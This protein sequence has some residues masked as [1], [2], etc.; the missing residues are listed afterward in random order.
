M[1]QIIA[2]RGAR[3]LAPE[4]TL[5]SARL[6]FELGAHMWETD[7]QQ[8]S[9]GHL[10]LLHDQ[11]LKRCT[12]VNKVFPGRTEDPVH[13]FSLDDLLRLDA[14]SYYMHADPFG[15]VAGG[16]V[17][18]K[19]SAKYRGEPIPTL[20]KALLFTKEKQWK[21]N[22]ELKQYQE[23]DIGTVLPERL[24]H[25]VKRSGIGKDNVVISSFYHPWLDWINDQDP[26]LAVQALLGEDNDAELEFL[27]QGLPLHRPARKQMPSAT[28][29]RRIYLNP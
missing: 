27:Q 21:I 14:G 29:Y 10:I 11:T 16:R 13:E 2:H 8:T 7:V 5:S 25:A 15:Q 23:G 26:T 4:N 28:A 24:L 3:S 19:M 9:D 18:M 17:S 22:L 1:V 20:D 6:A 12:D